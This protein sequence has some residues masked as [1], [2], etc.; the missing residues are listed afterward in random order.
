MSSACGKAARA[1]QSASPILIAPAR[2]GNHPGFLS[3]LGLSESYRSGDA[4]DV[5]HVAT[6]EVE[7][8]VGTVRG[9]DDEN[10]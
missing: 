6:G 2:R 10:V 9:C 1:M 3:Y 7:L 8:L 5:N 4:P